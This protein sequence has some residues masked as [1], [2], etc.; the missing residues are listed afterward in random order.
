MSA[1]FQSLLALP[2]DE[3]NAT[4][5]TMPMDEVIAFMGY[6]SKVQA[7]ETTR[8]VNEAK[9]KVTSKGGLSIKVSEK[10]GLSVYGMG[11]FPLTLYRS[12]WEKLIKH[13]PEIEAFI[14]ADTA[15]SNPR[16]TVKE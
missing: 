16:L 8:L 3:R 4:L 7:E 9:S 1:Q 2:A 14:A 10:G 6:A 13:I 12:Q 5:K 15:S 11:R